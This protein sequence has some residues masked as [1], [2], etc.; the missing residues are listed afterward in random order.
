[1]A[2]E[3]TPASEV[4]R[5]ADTL[6]RLLA[7]IG[8]N[9]RSVNAV[10]AARDAALASM[11]DSAGVTTPFQTEAA[12]GEI[13]STSKAPIHLFKVG[14][15]VT[16][17]SD[18]N[19]KL[20][21]LE[22]ITE[23]PEVRYRA[24]QDSAK[25]TYYESQLQAVGIGTAERPPIP[26]DEFRARL[27][28]LHL[29]SPSTANLF[30]LR[31]GRVNFVPYQYRPVLMSGQEKERAK[32][33]ESAS[34][35]R[36]DDPAK[37]GGKTR[38]RAGRSS[39]PRQARQKTARRMPVPHFGDK[40]HIPIDRKWRFIRGETGTDA[41]RYDGHEP[42]SVPDGTNSSKSVRADTG[43]RSA[44]NEA[45]LEVPYPPRQCHAVI[46]SG[47]RGTCLRTREETNGVR[48]IGEVRAAGRTT[49][50]NLSHTFRR[51]I[52]HERGRTAA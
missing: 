5:D 27:T 36:P 32:T 49:M 46:R 16:L 11:T 15:V 39:I 10:Q 38:T 2:A 51:F 8:A 24:F 47:L 14:D 50:A 41:A 31:S 18:R 52:F 34:D 44:R 21:V 25:A 7:L 20:P 12:T 22:V 17:R 29:L 37:A 9:E 4:Y 35:I 48:C 30:S 42:T 6:G 19:I 13:E 23:G 3:E 43:Y 40:N 1:M 45:W 26:I 28:A 33:G